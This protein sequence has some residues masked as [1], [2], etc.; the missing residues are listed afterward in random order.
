MDNRINF[1][2]EE[3]QLLY[4][5]CISYGSRLSDML[6]SIPNERRNITGGLSAR[7]D[8]SWKLVRK[9]TGCICFQHI[10]EYPAAAVCCMIWLL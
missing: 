6:K 3:L 7:A 1:P 10:I 9:I 4:A 2:Q 8:D 5:A